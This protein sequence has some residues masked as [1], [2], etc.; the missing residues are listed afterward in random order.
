MDLKSGYPRWAVRNGLIHAFP[1]LEENLRCDV[2][3]VVGTSGAASLPVHAVSAAA[4][5]GSIIVDVNPNQ[6]P[7][8]QITTQLPDGLWLPGEATLWVPR[9]VEALTA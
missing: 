8:S 6:G 7:F 2:L 3:V 5:R 9:V 4:R 1:P